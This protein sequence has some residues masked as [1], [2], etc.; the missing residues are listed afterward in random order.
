MTIAPAKRI[1]SLTNPTKKMS[2]SDP[3]PNSRILITDDE[4]TIRRKLRT[5]LTD[6]KEGIS[7]DPEN[8]PG[9]SSLLDILKHI[10]YEEISSHDL[11]ADFKNASLRSLKEA[12]AD[13]VTQALRDVREKFTQ[14]RSSP[15][16]HHE[17]GLNRRQATVSAAETL[18]EVKHAIGLL[19]SGQRLRGESKALPDSE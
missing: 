3:N 10:R 13:E 18:R 16:L 1:M 14:L 6:S 11:A 2:K 7:Y 15:S 4:G 9:V 12:V 17:T 5:A 8:R 19:P